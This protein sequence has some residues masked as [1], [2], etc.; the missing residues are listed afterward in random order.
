MFHKDFEELGGYAIRKVILEFFVDVFFGENPMGNH[1]AIQ[2]IDQMKPA[3]DNSSDCGLFVSKF[4]AQ[5]LSGK[6]SRLTKLCFGY[7]VS[8][9]H[10][11]FA[12]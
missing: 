1:N 11:R 10:V 9:T 8:S 3:Q 7:C 2:D 4:A 5:W 6:V 12:H